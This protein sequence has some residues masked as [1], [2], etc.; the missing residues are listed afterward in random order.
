MCFLRS[1]QPYVGNSS[2]YLSAALLNVSGSRTML[3]KTPLVELKELYMLYSAN[4]ASNIV[5]GFYAN[6]L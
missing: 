6:N 1:Y 3:F 5:W 4:R 2:V